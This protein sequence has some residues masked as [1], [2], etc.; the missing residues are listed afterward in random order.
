MMATYLLI[1]ESG[2]I[3][4]S[5]MMDEQGVIEIRTS[6]TQTGKM[7][8]H[9]ARLKPS[10]KMI[11]SEVCS[12]PLSEPL[13]ATIRRDGMKDIYDMFKETYEKLCDYDTSHKRNR[14]LTDKSVLELEKAVIKL[15]RASVLDMEM[16]DLSHLARNS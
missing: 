8:E 9:G 13:D 12:G 6:K 16:P 10:G 5:I 7:W 11:A 1:G 4:A 3:A 14:K 15:A 2:N